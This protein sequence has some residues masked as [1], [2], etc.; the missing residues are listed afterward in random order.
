MK[1]LGG[2]VCYADDGEVEFVLGEKFYSVKYGEGYLLGEEVDLDQLPKLKSLKYLAGRGKGV[3]GYRTFTHKGSP[4]D[5]L[6]R[7][8]CGGF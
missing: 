8:L 7:L 4:V 1:K 6:R 2:T 5:G 3:E